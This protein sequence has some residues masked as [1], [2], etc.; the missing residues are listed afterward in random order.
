MPCYSPLRAWQQAKGLPPVFKPPSHGIW[1]ELKLPC[2]QCVGCRLEYSRQW[3][4]RC[5]HESKMHKSNCFLT[6]TYSD[7]HYP[8]AGNLVY[9]D[10]QLFMKRLRKRFPDTPIQYYMCGEYGDLTKRPHFHAVIFGLDFADKRFFKSAGNEGSLYTSA[11]LDGLWGKGHCMIGDVTFE[12]C[13][14]VARYVMKRVNNDLAYFVYAAIDPITGEIIQLEP[15]FTHM[16][17]KRPIGK[18]WFDRY[19]SDVYPHDHVIVRGKAM[20]PPKY[21]DTLLGREDEAELI[22]VKLSREQKAYELPFDEQS[23]RRLR[24]KAAVTKARLKS[25]SL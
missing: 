22:R 16:S 1:P 21:Y 8:Y 19:Q 25:R 11:V 5:L 10:F 9:R 12:S 14:Y 3:A 6:L 7:E 17:L 2:G 18:S 23:P 13:A 4:M 24:D 15:E 20:K